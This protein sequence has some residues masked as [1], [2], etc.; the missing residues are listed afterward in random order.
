MSVRVLLCLIDTA[1]T[2]FAL[3]LITLEITE[4]I[5]LFRPDE[6]TIDVSWLAAAKT[7]AGNNLKQLDHEAIQET[8]LSIIH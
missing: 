4:G 6:N 7:D 8:D 5:Q 3:L 2:L 1:L